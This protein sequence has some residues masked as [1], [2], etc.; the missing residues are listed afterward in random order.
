MEVLQQ[1]VQQACNEPFCDKYSVKPALSSTWAKIYLVFLYHELLVWVIYNT[2]TKPPLQH[3][4][5][6]QSVTTCCAD[7]S[8]LLRRRLPIHDR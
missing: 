2:L 6:T 4:T 8:F 5:Q 7:M 3:P 1:L